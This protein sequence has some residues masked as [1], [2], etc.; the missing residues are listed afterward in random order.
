MAGNFVR[1]LFGFDSRRTFRVIQPEAQM[2]LPIYLLLITVGFA[3]F[4]AWH[5]HSAYSKFYAM[6]MT[7]VPESFQEQVLRQTHDFSIVGAAILGAFVLTLLGF[8]IA[9][10]HTLLGPIVPLRRHLQSLKDGN[11]K[12]RNQLRASDSAHQGL[13]EDLNELASILQHAQ[14]DSTSVRNAERSA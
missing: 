13:A 14:M 11:Y 12:A 9:Y 3:S 4:L 10:T 1:S 2:R 7:A 5:T 6:V 8:C